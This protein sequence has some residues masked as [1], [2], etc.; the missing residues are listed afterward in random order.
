MKKIIFSIVFGLIVSVAC[1]QQ[2]VNGGKLSKE[3]E[4]QLTSEQKLVRAT[5]KK[6]KQGKKKISTK[7]KVKIQEKQ[8]RRARR[9]KP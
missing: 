9:V 3:E 1:G 5:D 4:A 2:K 7:K 6:S 8:A